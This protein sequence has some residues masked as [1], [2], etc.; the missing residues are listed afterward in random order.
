MI[1]GKY[2]KIKYRKIE[3]RGAR[4]KWIIYWGRW[5]DFNEL[6]YIY[7]MKS[8]TIARRFYDHVLLKTGKFK[9]VAALCSNKTIKLPNGSGQAK[10]AK[11]GEEKEFVRDHS[12]K[13]K[14]LAAMVDPMATA[15]D[16]KK[17]QKLAYGVE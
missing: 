14:M 1:E 11:A 17:Y 5:R 6:A 7:G 13:A 9:T 12:A 8:E 4:P 3:Q 15:A 16:V 10:G 2:H